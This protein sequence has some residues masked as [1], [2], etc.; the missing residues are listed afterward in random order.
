MNKD[1]RRE[2]GTLRRSEE[3]QME[4]E[5][6]SGQQAAGKRGESQRNKRNVEHYRGSEQKR[7]RG[8]HGGNR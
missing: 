5:K 6:G 4:R 2:A 3:R 7:Q 1:L 8:N